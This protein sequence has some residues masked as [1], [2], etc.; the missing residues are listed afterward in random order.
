[1]IHAS[2]PP[3]LLNGGGILPEES[4]K[5]TYTYIYPRTLWDQRTGLQLER[6]NK[7]KGS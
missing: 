2:P 4:C 1:M 3:K 6:S 7:D 5:Q